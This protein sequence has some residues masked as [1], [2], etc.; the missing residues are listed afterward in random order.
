MD[1]KI[2]GDFFSDHGHHINVVAISLSKA[3][4]ESHGNT[5]ALNGALLR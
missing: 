3:L 1:T 5:C 2:N 4:F